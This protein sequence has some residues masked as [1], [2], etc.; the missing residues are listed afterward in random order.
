MELKGNQGRLHSEV[1]DFFETALAHNFKHADHK[2]Y[3][4]H[5]AA[6]G[7]AVTR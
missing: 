2:H 7:R 6:H 3:R 5:D 1:K 4:E